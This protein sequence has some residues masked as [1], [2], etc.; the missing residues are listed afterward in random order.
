MST[1]FGN[2][3]VA[4]RREKRFPFFGTDFLIFPWF[5][6]KYFIPSWI[7]VF[8]GPGYHTSRQDSILASIPWFVFTSLNFAS[9]TIH[10]T[11]FLKSTPCQHIDVVDIQHWLRQILISRAQEKQE[12]PWLKSRATTALIHFSNKQCTSSHPALFKVHTT[13]NSWAQAPRLRWS[14]FYTT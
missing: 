10:A 9:N 5:S 6:L 2:E 14:Y 1:K 11:Q 12:S 7:L 13:C 3:I 8:L 4:R